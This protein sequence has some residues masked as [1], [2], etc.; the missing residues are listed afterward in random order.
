MTVEKLPEFFCLLQMFT[1]DD[2]GDFENI[3]FNCVVGVETLAK[4]LL[5][6]IGSYEITLTQCQTPVFLTF[7]VILAR[8]LLVSR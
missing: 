3:L 2:I 1:L 8:S 4:P 6:L 5:C 7:T